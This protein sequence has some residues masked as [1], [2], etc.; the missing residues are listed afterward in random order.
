MKTERTYEFKFIPLSPI[1]HLTFLCKML[2]AAELEEEET[3][4]Y[5]VVESAEDSVA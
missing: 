4:V 1:Q 2:E 3:A 5:E